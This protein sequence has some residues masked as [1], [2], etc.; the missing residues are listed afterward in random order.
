MKPEI[1][2]KDKNVM[3]FTLAVLTLSVVILGV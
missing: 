3:T 1:T 2:A